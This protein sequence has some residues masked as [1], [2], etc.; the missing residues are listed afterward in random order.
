MR[1]EHGKDVD[2][3]RRLYE[4]VYKSPNIKSR[5]DPSN[6]GIV[7]REAER[8]SAI[9]RLVRDHGY[10]P[11]SEQSILEVGCGDGSNLS[12]LVSIGAT[13]GNLC[14]LDLVPE[15]ISAAKSGN[16][17]MDFQVGNAEDL[18]YESSSFD[19]VLL[20]TVFS[21]VSES[22]SRNVADEVSRVLRVGG[23]VL[24]YDTRYPNPSNP[25]T[26]PVSRTALERYFPEFEAD[27]RTITL[28]PP[29]SRLLGRL[30]PRLCSRL[31]MIPVL[32]SHHLAVMTKRR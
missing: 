2:G 17:S 31:S 8:W 15:R 29:L 18:P 16:P 10:L 1:T 4:T 5:W 11:L 7:Q 32:R 23:A 19:L 27:I 20:F 9:E 24:F 14:G 22:I 3:V 6:P 26:R 12:M 30:C 25:Y 21:S 28:L 13:P